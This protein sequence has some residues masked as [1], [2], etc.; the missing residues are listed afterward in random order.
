MILLWQENIYIQLINMSV[1]HIDV[2]V[3]N[4]SDN[5]GCFLTEFYGHWCVNQRKHSWK[6]L[7]K[8]GEYRLLPWVVIG[9]FNEL[10]LTTEIDSLRGRPVSQ[11]SGLRGRPES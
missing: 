6:L 4:W 8:I 5:G 10:L 3:S 11:M 7:R 1:G 2:W 9:D